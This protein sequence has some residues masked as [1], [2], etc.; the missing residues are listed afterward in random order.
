MLPASSDS[1][2][3]RGHGGPTL[4][5]DTPP[6]TL[7]GRVLA[8]GEKNPPNLTQLLR[9]W[10]GGDREALDRLVPLVYAELRRLSH[11]YL[12]RGPHRTL[13][14]TALINEAFVKLIGQDGI[15]WESRAHFFGIA[16]RTMRN[17]VV[18]HARE[19]MAA[20]RGGGREELLFDAELFMV[21]EKKGWGLV[22]L[23]DA[24]EELAEI[25]PQLSKL[26]ELRF[27]AG[28]TVEETAEVLGVS[29]RTVKRGWRTAKIW[30]L[31]QLEHR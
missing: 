23:D 6:A 30:L 8:V 17:I 20:K 10:G 2:A 1:G 29:P 27:F 16:A 7:S 28:M 21:N 4:D 26:V 5:S 31:R 14:T 18:D 19:A 12:Q 13:Q 22:A 25:D 15:S 11:H 24:L 3:K 9:D